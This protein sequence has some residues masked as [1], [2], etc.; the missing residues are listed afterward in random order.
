M[1]LYFYFILF[2]SYSLIAQCVQVTDSKD[3]FSF[4]VAADMRGYAEPEYRSSE[5]FQGVCEAIKE[6]GRGKFMISPGDID[7]PYHVNKTI[8][9][10]LGEDYFWYP[11]LGN[12]E[13]ET[14]EDMLF[15]NSYLSSDIPNLVN[16]GPEN[17]EKTM[18][19]F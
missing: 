1:K 17:C 14:E 2:I 10:I 8:Q 16:E 12:H 13:V 4:D 19:S 18:Y 11:V 15:L 5:Y 6:V 7:P 9:E 3:S